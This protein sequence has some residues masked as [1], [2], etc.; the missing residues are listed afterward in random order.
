MGD[1]H[2]ELVVSPDKSRFGRVAWAVV[3]AAILPGISL[4]LMLARGRGTSEG[5]GPAAVPAAVVLV[6]L[7]FL[8]YVTY[9]VLHTV[10]SYVAFVDDAVLV[11]NWV[12]RLTVIEGPGFLVRTSIDSSGTADEVLIVGDDRVAVMLNPRQ[13]REAEL[14]R[15]WRRAALSPQPGG[16]PTPREL[17]RRYPTIRIPLHI[18][19]PGIVYTFWTV[20]VIL[21]IGTVINVFARI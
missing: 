7:P 6:A 16:M 1:R 9:A 13:W 12:R 11:R 3:P 17:R 15:V 19:H 18:R 2:T 21:Y 5:L 20:L 14:D 8:W 10:N 4:T